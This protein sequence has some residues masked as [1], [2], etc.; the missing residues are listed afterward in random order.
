MRGSRSNQR[1]TPDQRTRVRVV[2]VRALEGVRES[3]RMDV[4]DKDDPEF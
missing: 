1:P 4:Y 2:A 3:R